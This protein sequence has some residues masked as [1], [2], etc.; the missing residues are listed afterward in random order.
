MRTRRSLEIAANVAILVVASLI[1]A[2]FVRSKWRPSE[3]PEAPKIG[4]R[5]S[6]PGSKWEDRP[7]LVM[8][9]QKGCK[10]CDDSSSFY[11]RL[12][13][14]RSGS[15]P[16]MLAVIPGDKTEIA[17]YLSQQGILVDEVVNASLSE[18]KVL[19]TP[20]LLLVDR[21]GMVTDVWVGKLNASEESEVIRRIS[22]SH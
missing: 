20:T 4:S 10:Y 17:S 18:I 14:R 21:S 15:L 12:H 9:L 8:A 19:Y 6:L 11:R 16:R 7:T 3:Q 1:I 2:N 13:E 5:I 22:S